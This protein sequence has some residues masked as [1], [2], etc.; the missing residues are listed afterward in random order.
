MQLNTPYRYLGL[1]DSDLSADASRSIG[2]LAQL[3]GVNNDVLQY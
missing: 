1:I 2:Q 3:D